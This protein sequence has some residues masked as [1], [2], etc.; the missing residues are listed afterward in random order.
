MGSCTILGKASGS[1]S[2]RGG[3]PPPTQAGTPDRP[4]P[5][6]EL[7]A[8]L[9]EALIAHAAVAALETAAPGDPAAAEAVYSL[10]GELEGSS[11]EGAATTKSIEP[12]SLSVFVISPLSLVS[13]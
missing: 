1:G 4:P 6:V 8:A 5:A 9:R 11:L 2:N 12:Y 3:A 10:A 13:P 7:A